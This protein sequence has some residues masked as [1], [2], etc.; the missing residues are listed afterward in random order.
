[1]LLAFAAPFLFTLYLPMRGAAGAFLAP[2][3]LATLPG[4]FEHVLARGFEGDF[5]YFAR[6]AALPDRL[7]ILGNILT[8]QFNLWLLLG[9]AGG[10]LLA[11]WRDWKLFA[12]LAGSFAVHAFVAVTYRAPQTVEYMLPAYVVLA[13]A[14]G[15]GLGE[16]QRHF[17]ARF[18]ASALRTVPDPARPAQ[19][20]D[21][22]AHHALRITSYALHASFALATLLLLLR[23]LPSYAVL[24]RDRSAREYAERVLNDAPSGTLVLASWHWATPLWYLQQVEGARPDVTVEYVFPQGESLADNWVERLAANVGQRPVIVTSFYASEYDRTGYRFLPFGPAWLAAPETVTSLDYSP[25]VDADFEGGWRLA[26]YTV[27]SGEV[28][29]GG[30]LAAT[31]AWVGPA[32][33]QDINFFA[34]LIG[35]DGALYG[36][37]DVAHPAALGTAGDWLIDRYLITVRPDALPGEY[38]L[39]A[40]AYRADGTRLLIAGG[41][42]DYYRLVTV[43]V[44]LADRPAVTRHRVMRPFT[45]PALVGYDYDRSLPD[46]L[47]LYL[48]WRLG[49]APQSTTVWQG[50]SPY[51]EVALPAGPGYWTSALDLPA[52]ATGVQVVVGRPRVPGLFDWNSYALRPPGAGDRYVPLGG[53]MVLVAAHAEQERPGEVRVDLELLSAGPLLEDDIVKVDL[54]GPGYAWRAESNS[55]PAGGAIPTLKWVDGSRVH[56]RHRLTIPADAAAGAARLELAVY[57]HFTGRV[58]PI[59]DPRLAVLGPTVPLGQ[60]EIEK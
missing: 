17:V 22:W 15:F 41:T 26:T 8:F 47:R 32:A 1:L 43:N 18:K 45:A 38:S 10:L 7:A 36:Q 48:H 37:M 11:L 12:L 34:Q 20:R 30:T 23:N 28:R 13:V 44:A 3:H 60:V 57:N 31:V 19:F 40:G 14:L 51:A 54:I 42:Q 59:L 49:A 6:L 53:A 35:P 2:S 55:V 56:D 33:P 52:V 27:E 16:L 4:F 5:F 46:S 39:I 29:P 25:A 9:M 21:R 24:A 58:L 50:G